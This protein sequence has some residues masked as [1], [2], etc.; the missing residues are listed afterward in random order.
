MRKAATPTKLYKDFSEISVHLVHFSKSSNYAQES[1]LKC[2]CSEISERQ[3]RYTENEYGNID[4]K[5]AFAREHVAI[6]IQ[7]YSGC[8]SLTS[9]RIFK[10]RKHVI[11]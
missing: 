7:I 6:F 11:T 10:L 1:G 9:S 2:V 8:T 4:S 5:A 3:V